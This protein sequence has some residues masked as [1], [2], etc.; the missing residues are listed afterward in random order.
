MTGPETAGAA[1]LDMFSSFNSTAEIVGDA[2]NA[3]AKNIEI[4]NMMKN[5]Q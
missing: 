4:P 2:G 3:I 5:L 1:V